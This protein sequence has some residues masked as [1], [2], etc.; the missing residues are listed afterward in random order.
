M[1]DEVLAN[2]AKSRGLKPEDFK[3]REDAIA[4]LQLDDEAS[5]SDHREAD[6]KGL[7]DKEVA[8]H[9]GNITREVPNDLGEYEGRYV[10]VKDPLPGEVFGLKIVPGTRHGKDYHAKSQIRFGDYTKEEFR[11]LFDKL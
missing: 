7:S 4:H 3:T 10:L 11:T 9:D 6:P 2:E 1:S 8:T 5:A